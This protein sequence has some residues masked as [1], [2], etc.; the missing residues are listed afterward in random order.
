MF[1]RNHASRCRVPEKE[2]CSP[3]FVARLAT[4]EGDTFFVWSE[5]RIGGVRKNELV[6]EAESPFREKK[7]ARKPESIWE[8]VRTAL[9]ELFHRVIDDG[10]QERVP[11]GVCAHFQ[12]S[13]GD[14]GLLA[15]PPRHQTALGIAIVGLTL[16]WAAVCTVVFVLTVES[17]HKMATLH[18]DWKADLEHGKW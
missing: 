9:T 7:Q 15:L 5:T 1:R 17:C 14:I 8:Q 13:R 2:N 12:M 11:T 3:K 4:D 18:L 6:V 10:N 16:G